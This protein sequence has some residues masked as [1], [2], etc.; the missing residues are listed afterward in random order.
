[1][2]LILD[3]SES[4][5]IRRLRSVSISMGL[6]T[7]FLTGRQLARE[8]EID[9]YLNDTETQFYLSHGDRQISIADLKAVYCGL[10]VFAPEWWTCFDADDAAYAAQECFALWLSILASL[11]C[12]V[13]NRPAMDSLAGSAFPPSQFYHIAS[14]LGFKIPLTM[15][16]ESGDRAMELIALGAPATFQDLGRIDAIEVH[17]S[18]GLPA[19]A[20]ENHIYIKEVVPGLPLYLSLV[21]EQIFVVYNDATGS[22][23]SLP[24]EFVPAVVRERV[25][26]LHRVL[27]LNWAEY[28][29]S[30]SRE[31]SWIIT[32]YERCPRVAMAALGDELLAA[33]VAQIIYEG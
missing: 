32:G 24:A 23:R 2:F 30:V 10:D 26:V 11:P 19:Q 14:G 15:V 27:H 18:Q 9:Y 17:A 29:F 8:V 31:G 6:E 25:Q 21:G 20:R 7:L 1:M 16:L 12:R 33:M 13:I 28:Q 22:L 3:E 5:F 4:E